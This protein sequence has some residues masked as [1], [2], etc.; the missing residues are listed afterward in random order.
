MAD[1]KRK[2]AQAALKQVPHHGWTQDAITA[3]VLEHPNMSIS[4]AGMLTPSELVNWLMDSFNEELREKAEE[5]TVFEKIQWRLQQVAP[6]VQSGQWH[7][8]MAMG[9]S[10]PVTTRSQLHEFVEIIAPPNSTI[11]YKTALGGIF[12]ATE[13][14]LLTDSSPDYLETWKFLQLR[15]DELE[16]GEFANL[17]DSSSIPMAATS[18]VATSLFEGISSLLAPPGSNTTGT[19]AR[20]YT[21]KE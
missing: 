4:M 3:A 10:T 19:K 8:A 2:L 17:F 9:L 14:H 20:D 1:H 15:L 6:L 7:K 5:W 18:A 13:L 12:V 21:F 11:I 16:R